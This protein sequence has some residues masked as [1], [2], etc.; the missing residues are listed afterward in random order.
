[1]TESTTI[2]DILTNELR[3]AERDLAT[4]QADQARYEDAVKQGK[5]SIKMTEDRIADIMASGILK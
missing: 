3:R 5:I 2:K 4:K 1:M